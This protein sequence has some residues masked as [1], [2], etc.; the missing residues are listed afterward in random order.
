MPRAVRIAAVSLIASLALTSCGGGERDATTRAAH[1]FSAARAFRDLRSE[2]GLGPR[3]ARS[4][5]NR[6][7]AA[8]IAR[9]LR[10][11]GARDVRVQRPW[12]NV[13]ARIPGS[14]PGAVVLGAHRDT[15][16]IQGFI[17]ANDGASGVAVLLELARDL[18]NPLPGPS[19][20]LAFFDAEESSGA[21]DGVRAFERTGD[22]GSR[23]YLRYAAA[24]GRQG[25][26][27]LRSIRAMV[28]FDMVGDCKL[29]IP[30][31]A[32]SSAS[33]YMLFRN[34]AGPRNPFEGDAPAIL[35]DQTPFER[36]GIAS[37]DLIDFDYGPG[38]PPGA[39]WHTTKDNLKHVCARSLAAVGRPSLAAIPSIP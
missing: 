4:P 1:P 10:A 32:S 31:E 37:L 28:L 25:S 5:A 24:G 11:A 35:D 18:P 2:V 9:R 26:P 23:Q 19:V 7:D 33:L 14:E 13:V 39:Y 21:G 22:R 29:R 17:G 38:P 20:D 30:R 27:A 6:R 34:A 3:P 16:H 12:R 36:A 8:F 15:K